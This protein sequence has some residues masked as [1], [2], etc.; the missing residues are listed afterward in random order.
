MDPATT[1]K[2]APGPRVLRRTEELLLLL[3]VVSIL[4]ICAVI[5]IGVVTRALF[6]W[7]LPDAEIFVRDLMITSIILPLAYVTAER[8][9]IAVDVFVN[10][11]PDAMRGWSDLLG[12][13][14]GFLVLLPVAYGG[15]AGF[16][17][18]WGDG[19]YYY[20]EFEM[21]EW[22]GKLAFFLGYVVFLLRLA[23]LVVADALNVLRRG[24]VVANDHE[25]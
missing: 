23:V 4:S 1:T 16:A 15:W 22:P 7:S 2:A 19:N 20:G 17:A 8:A 11:M 6:D 5:F 18:A 14:V 3:A 25:G 21:P 10:L 13:L 24:H 9:H 12:S